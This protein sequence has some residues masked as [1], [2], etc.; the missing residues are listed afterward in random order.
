MACGVPVVS[1]DVSES[2]LVQESGAGLISSGVQ[3]FAGNIVRFAK[4]ATLRERLGQ[5]GRE[6]AKPFDWDVLAER[7]QREVLDMFAP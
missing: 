2:F 3:D 1:T 5:K 6:F 4:D 7:Y